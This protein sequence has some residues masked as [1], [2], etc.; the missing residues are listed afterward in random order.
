MKLMPARIS[1]IDNMKAIGIVL[2]VLGHT[3]GIGNTAAQF[4]FSFHMP[5]FF[6]ASGLLLKEEAVKNETAQFFVRQVYRLVVPYTFFWLVSYSYWIVSRHFLSQHGVTENAQFWLEPIL[7]YF[8]GTGEFLFIN[9]VLWFFSCLFVTSMLFHFIR[10]IAHNS[11][12]VIVLVLSGICGVA[13]SKLLG[14]RV[15]WNVDL[16]LIAVLFY[17]TGHLLRPVLMSRQGIAKWRSEYAVIGM[18][19]AAIAA[20]INGRVDMNNMVFGN[21]LWFYIGAFA[22]IAGVLGISMLLPPSRLAQSVGRNTIVIF[23]LHVILFGVFAGI[24]ML[25]LELP[26]EFKD[27]SAVWSALFAVAAILFSVPLA[28]FA[29]QT[30]PWAIGESRVL[31]DVRMNT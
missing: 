29:R 5:L 17:G 4:I 10:K 13:L 24:G 8:Y 3:K 18:T 9:P 16:A 6:F 11:V 2:V 14:F 26:R 31:D 19:V 25:F 27:Q 23:P 12:V 20:V 22:G 30:A 15:P 1:W 21:I 28:Y 7:G